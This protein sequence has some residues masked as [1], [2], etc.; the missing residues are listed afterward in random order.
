MLEVVDC[1]GTMRKD[2]GDSQLLR[3]LIKIELLM[4]RQK[5]MDSE[6]ELKLKKFSIYIYI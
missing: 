3:Y 6:N 2:E 1:G 5:L 4:T